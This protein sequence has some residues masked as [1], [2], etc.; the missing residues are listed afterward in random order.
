M[1]GRAAWAALWGGMGI[2]CADRR[3]LA[4]IVS[5]LGV[6][7]FLSSAIA[8]DKPVEGA[9][10]SSGH[11][12]NTPASFQIWRT[13][14]LGSHKGVDG[15]RDALD[16]AG[17]KIGDS[18]DEILGRPM[19]P[20]ATVKTEVALVLFSVEELG[21]DVR[22]SSLSGVYKRA[23]QIGLEMCPAEV[24]PRLRLDYRNQPLGEACT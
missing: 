2:S 3:L 12:V 6:A 21:V 14:T 1:Q 17:I 4:P 5:C 11:N 24:G 7:V 15:Y 19:F 20:Y 23:R 18:A 9:Q 16:A 22:A 8:L 10:P 13:T